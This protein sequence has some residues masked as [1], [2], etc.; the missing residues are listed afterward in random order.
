M[1]FCTL[2]GQ[3]QKSKTTRFFDLEAT[4]QRMETGNHLCNSATNPRRTTM[5]K[6][7]TNDFISCLDKKNALPRTKKNELDQVVS[8]Q[9]GREGARKSIVV[10]CFSKNTV[11]DT[12]MFTKVEN[13]N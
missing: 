2:V 1:F 5:E 6:Y 11:N 7:K 8:F 10:P 4:F 3:G 9:S 12:S 13:K